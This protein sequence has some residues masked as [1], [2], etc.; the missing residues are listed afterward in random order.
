[1]RADLS[2]HTYS[3]ELAPALADMQA[4]QVEPLTQP[5]FD[6]SAKTPPPITAA[7]HQRVLGQHLS[8]VPGE[9]PAF[10]RMWMGLMHLLSGLGARV[11]THNCPALLHVTTHRN[12]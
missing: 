9:M 1:V 2:Q 12:P 8:Q 11:R 10:E 3:T 5:V 4:W 7:R 6:F